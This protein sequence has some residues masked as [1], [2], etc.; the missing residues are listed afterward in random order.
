[1]AVVFTGIVLLDG[2]LHHAHSSSVK[3]KRKNSIIFVG[4]SVY[5]SSIL[6]S[7]ICLYFLFVCLTSNAVITPEV[8]KLKILALDCFT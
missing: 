4:L 2:V 1:M 5:H 6:T 7:T 3:R 8:H